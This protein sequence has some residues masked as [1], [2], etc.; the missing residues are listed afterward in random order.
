[1][2]FSKGKENSKNTVATEYAMG[3]KR[4]EVALGTVDN[5]KVMKSLVRRLVGN[6]LRVEWQPTTRSITRTAGKTT[7]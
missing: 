2:N 5:V 3:R 7:R 6:S 1:M 4:A